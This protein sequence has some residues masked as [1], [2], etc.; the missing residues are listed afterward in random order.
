MSRNPRPDKHGG[1]GLCDFPSE[2]GESFA[3]NVPTFLIDGP[4]PAYI[5][6]ITCNGG[7]CCLLNGKEHAV[8]HIGFQL[9]QH[10]D[11]G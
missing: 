6:L 5:T 3:E 1:I 7:N 8:I 11:N 4:Y 10:G 2:S 9:F